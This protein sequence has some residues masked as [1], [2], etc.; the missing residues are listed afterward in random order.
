M[1][2]PFDDEAD[3]GSSTHYYNEYYKYYT[4]YP[5]S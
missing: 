5:K 3:K 4:D 2:N 1:E